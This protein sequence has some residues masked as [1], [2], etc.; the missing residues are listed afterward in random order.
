[1]Y[2]NRKSTI[3]QNNKIMSILTNKIKAF[4]FSNNPLLLLF[5]SLTQTLKII[6]IKE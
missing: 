6:I 1:M 2:M 5:L 4:Y 3:K